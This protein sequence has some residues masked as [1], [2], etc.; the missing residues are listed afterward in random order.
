MNLEGTKHEKAVL[1][2]VAY[3]IGLC[4]GF[5]GFGLSPNQT[6]HEKTNAIMPM[7]NNEIIHEGYVPPT[8]HPPQFEETPVVE[9]PSETEVSSSTDETVSYKDGKLY[10]NAGGEMFLLSL[11]ND[12][13]PV[14]NVEGFATQGIHKDIPAYNVSASG[15]YVYFCEQQ[16]ETLE[17]TNMI[18][19]TETK[20]IQFVAFAGEKVVTSDANAKSAYWTGDILTVG[21]Y[22]S[23]AT[24][25]PW[26]MSL[27]E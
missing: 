2:I 20:L 17:C 23:T 26:K 8:T 11:R 3:I 22:Q 6:S 5:I 4:S 12:I 7:A 15:R 18:F 25:E 24:A 27:T 16:T 10:A 1:V 13:M 9:E 21:K 19:D 14:N